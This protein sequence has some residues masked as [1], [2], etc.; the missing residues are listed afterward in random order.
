MSHWWLKS[1][2]SVR[3]V[4]S[5]IR[6]WPH[7]PTRHMRHATQTGCHRWRPPEVNRQTREGSARSCPHRGSLNSC[8][9]RL[10]GT[11][12]LRGPALALTMAHHLREVGAAPLTHS[13]C[14]SSSSLG[15][16][17][18]D[19]RMPI[20]RRQTASAS[21]KRPHHRNRKATAGCHLR[22][23]W[24][25]VL[26]W[27]HATN[28]SPWTWPRAQTSRLGNFSKKTSHELNRRMLRNASKNRDSR[29]WRF[30]SHR[31]QRWFH[32]LICQHKRCPTSYSR[33]P[34]QSARTSRIWRGLTSSLRSPYPTIKHSRRSW[35]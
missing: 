5:A 32:P 21:M 29:L 28:L 7:R 33:W 17:A 4:R 1:R 18:S 24:W 11:K 22:P 10:Q 15:R 31:K 23:R 16:M 19:P 13:T 3:K 2:H 14:Q 9:L 8:H 6:R 20:H 26:D 27:K 35:L 34:S 30:R 12:S 25:T